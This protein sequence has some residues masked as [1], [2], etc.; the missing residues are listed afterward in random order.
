MIGRLLDRSW[1]TLYRMVC[2]DCKGA[3][4]PWQRRCVGRHSVCQHARM[5][6]V[7]ERNA[8]FGYDIKPWPCVDCGTVP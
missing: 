4:W 3:I 7:R 5:R 1:R 2:D 8:A 6:A